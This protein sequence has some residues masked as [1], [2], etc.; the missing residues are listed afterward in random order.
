MGSSASEAATIPSYLRLD[1][2]QSLGVPIVD[3]ETF[4]AA[5]AEYQPLR[6]RFVNFANVMV[7]QRKEARNLSD[8]Y[9]SCSLRMEKLSCQNVR[10]EN[11]T[12]KVD[13]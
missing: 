8:G 12:D 6:A 2:L 11:P 4:A 3:N 5:L 13:I 10:I 1:T 7:G 9:I